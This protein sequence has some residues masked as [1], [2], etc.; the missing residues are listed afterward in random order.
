ML[1]PLS[2][3]TNPYDLSVGMPERVAAEMDYRYGRPRSSQ[4]YAE[5]GT[6]SGTSPLVI[7]GVIGA[8][9]LAYKYTKKAEGSSGGAVASGSRASE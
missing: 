9:F 5:Q 3:R 8:L 2:V 4:S 7:A 6:T 1:I